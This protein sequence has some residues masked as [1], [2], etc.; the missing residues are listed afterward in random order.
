MG[1]KK[2]WIGLSILL[3]LVLTIIILSVSLSNVKSKYKLA[4]HNYE[5]SKS[6]LV[7]TKTKNG[8][9]LAE[10]QAYILNEKNLMEELDI[11]KE[12]MKE[13]NN[14]LSKQAAYISKLESDIRIDTVEIK[15]DSIVYI[16]NT[17]AYIHFS[18]NDEWFKF[19]GETNVLKNT[20]KIYDV[21]VP[22]PLTIGITEAYTIFVKSP[23]PYLDISDINAVALEDFIKEKEKRKHWGFGVY[24]GFGAHYGLF[25]K[26]VDIGPQIGVGVLCILIV[27]LNLLI[28][29]F[30]YIT[31]TRK[32]T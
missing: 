20:T 3:I 12:E 15:N 25:T 26:T 21:N 13:L 6:E 16:D 9:L 24:G 1:S 2:F 27:V 5:V 17:P 23:N 28:W 4:N 29:E 14:K 10:K 30:M 11:S 18:N 8:E 7:K 31:R 19:K 32:H 22:M